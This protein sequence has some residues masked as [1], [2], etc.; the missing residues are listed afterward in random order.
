MEIYWERDYVNESLQIVD[1]PEINMPLFCFLVF[2]C[3]FRLIL[4]LILAYYILVLA[5]VR[6]EGGTG[7]EKMSGI[8]CSLNSIPK[9]IQEL[10]LKLL[11][12]KHLL[13]M[14]EATKLRGV[15]S[16]SAAASAAISHTVV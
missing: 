16:S 13:A 9:K 15:T 14:F 1:P 11:N 5:A 4:S 3:V 2:L 10:Q 6:I 7:W 8:E 12:A